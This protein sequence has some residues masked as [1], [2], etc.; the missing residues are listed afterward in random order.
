MV[1]FGLAAGDEPRVVAGRLRRGHDGT[2]RGLVGVQG[3]L[4]RLEVGMGWAWLENHLGMGGTYPMGN[5]MGKMFGNV[6]KI[7]SQM[8]KIE[9]LEFSMR[10]VVFRWI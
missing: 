7:E 9:N 6:G 5:C 2:H 1:R 8:R 4:L 3:L 10:N